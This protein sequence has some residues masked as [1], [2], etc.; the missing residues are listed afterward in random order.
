MSRPSVEMVDPSSFTGERKSA[1]TKMIASSESVRPSVV[2]NV[3]DLVSRGCGANAV[4]EGIELDAVENAGVESNSYSDNVSPSSP[5]GSVI[6][7]LARQVSHNFVQLEQDTLLNPDLK[8]K[9]ESEKPE[10]VSWL[11]SHMGFLLQVFA[12]ILFV[13]I[14]V[15]KAV[16]TSKAL[17]G[18]RTVSQSIAVVQSL[19]AVVIGSLT[20][21]CFDGQAGLRR[22]VS[23]QQFLKFA[24]Q[25]VIFAI[26]QCVG[27]LS[28]RE[29]PAGTI[30]ILGQARLMQTAALSTLVLKRKYVSLQWIMLVAI[31][32]A[33]VNFIMGKN[34]AGA[35][36]TEQHDNEAHLACLASTAHMLKN[37]S[38]TTPIDLSQPQWSCLTRAFKPT[39]EP[40][41]NLALGL[42]YAGSYLLL[43]D[44]G[45]IISE[46]MLKDEVSTGFYAQK[47][48]M[49]VIGCPVA[50]LMSIVVPLIMRAVD[51]PDVS[52]EWW[53]GHCYDKARVPCNPDLDGSQCQ[54]NSFFMN[55]NLWPIWVAVAFSFGQSWM[56]GVIVKL[57]SSVVKLVGKCVSLAMVYFVAECWVLYNPARP[58]TGSQHVAALCVLVGTYMFLTFNPPKPKPTGG[59]TQA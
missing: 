51:E 7:T 30:K 26:A 10:T 59:S 13:G 55:W 5:R 23:K 35:F 14:D 41:D 16:F 25:S 45:S 46:K 17:K 11:R 42:A 34:M 38:L 31:V 54:C 33:A 43:S 6:M 21:L 9:L 44:V 2:A 58:P 12:F 29:L 1:A 20:T 8:K 36:F 3:R 57:M 48:T 19:L 53:T 40:G 4:Y 32:L 27:F 24:P 18:T 52:L 39:S 28:Y 56:S 47:V 37:S 50:F 22:A 15:G 49:E